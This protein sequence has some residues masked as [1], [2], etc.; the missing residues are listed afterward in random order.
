LQDHNH[1]VALPQPLPARQ[2]PP[3]ELLMRVVQNIMDRLHGDLSVS[4]LARRFSLE[5]GVLFSVFQSHTGIALDQFVLRRRIERALDLLKNSRASACLHP[6]AG[7]N[8]KRYRHL[9]KPCGHTT[10]RKETV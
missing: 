6:V 3:T 5:E 2:C 9:I 1:A 7:L 4:A 10:A 8:L